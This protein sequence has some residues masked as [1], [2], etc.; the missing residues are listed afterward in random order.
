MNM[1]F[2]Y[3]NNKI[4]YNHKQHCWE[5]YSIYPYA[6]SYGRDCRYR[7]TKMTQDALDLNPDYFY[8]RHQ[9]R[10]G[11]LSLKG[12]KHMVYKPIVYTEYCKDDSLYVNYTN[13]P[14]IPYK[15][16][17]MIGLYQNYDIILSGWDMIEFVYRCD[18][19][20]ETR[21][22]VMNQIEQRI[23]DGNELQKNDPFSK[24]MDINELPW[25]KDKT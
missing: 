14:I 8:G 5:T 25:R 3:T 18:I 10:W 15:T 12:V 1:V 22:K 17:Y 23:L 4:K 19:D 9:K 16:E 6:Y 24:L 7:A 21:H 13:K 20:E 11:W 2:F